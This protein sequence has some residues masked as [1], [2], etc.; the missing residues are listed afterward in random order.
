MTPK[1]RSAYRPQWRLITPQIIVSVALV[2]ATVI[3]IT[4]L[5]MGV[6][7]PIG[8]AVNLGWAAFDLV[9]LSVLVPAVRDRG[10]DNK[11]EE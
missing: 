7:E 10:F 2:L 5:L 4:R 1:V 9:V 6:G 8:T 3:G 11:Q